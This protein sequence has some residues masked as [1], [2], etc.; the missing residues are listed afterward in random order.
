[1][2]GLAL[3]TGTVWLVIQG[4][5]TTSASFLDTDLQVMQQQAALP[6]AAPGRHATQTGPERYRILL[7]RVIIPAPTATPEPQPTPDGTRREVQIPI[8][9]YHYVD[10]PGPYADAIRQDLSVPPEM[11]ETHLDRIQ[12][13]GYETITMKKLVQHMALGSPLPDKPVV[14]TFDDGYVDHY[15]EVFPRLKARGMVGSFY[16]IS[17]YPHSGN[18]A[19]MTWDMI[20]EMQAW[21]ME[22]EAHSNEN[23]SLEGRTEAYLK[24]VA[25]AVLYRFEQELGIRPRIITY[26]MGHFDNNTIQVFQEEGYWAGLTTRSGVLHESDDLFRIHRVRIHGHTNAD[27]VEW[28]LSDEGLSQLRSYQ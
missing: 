10:V 9:M 12:A 8:L 5:R 16:V 20:R 14:L 27:Q 18:T 17:E 11:F 1:M 21:G 25:Q 7:G 28:L 22:I 6:L 13:L 24:E 2:L 26:P 15:T 19:Y 3:L 4:Q 23:A